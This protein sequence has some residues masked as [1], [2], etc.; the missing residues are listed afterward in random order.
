V[1][2]EN[3]NIFKL[4]YVKVIVNLLRL[5]CGGGVNYS[6]VKTKTPKSS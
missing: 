5:L 1:G 2:V 4:A 6:G 3:Q